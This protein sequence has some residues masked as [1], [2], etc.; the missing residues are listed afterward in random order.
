M[1]FRFAWREA[2]WKWLPSVSAGNIMVVDSGSVNFQTFK[3][4]IV[5]YDLLQRRVDEFEDFQFKVVIMVS[6]VH[7]VQHMSLL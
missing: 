4:V 2:I 7:D 1:T 6:F 5:S 3:V